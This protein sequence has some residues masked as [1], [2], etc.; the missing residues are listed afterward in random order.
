MA[1]IAH[2]FDRIKLGKMMGAARHASVVS[3]NL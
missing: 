3:V 1:G 2:I